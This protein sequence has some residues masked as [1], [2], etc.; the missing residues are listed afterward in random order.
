MEGGSTT[1]TSRKFLAR[2]F[3]LTPSGASPPPFPNS[4]PFLTPATRGLLSHRTF[5]T[6]FLFRRCAVGRGVGG[7]VDEG[8]A[9]REAKELHEAGIGKRMGTDKKVFTRILTQA[10]RPQ[11][12][13]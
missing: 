13:V 2:L 9:V 6:T 10:S 5:L 8:L 1:K 4:R 12:K 3:F 7:K 11:I